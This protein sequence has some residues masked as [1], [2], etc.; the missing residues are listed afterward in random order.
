MKNDTF[1]TNLVANMVARA[2]KHPSATC[3]EPVKH[4][5]T[6]QSNRGAMSG[7]NSSSSTIVSCASEYT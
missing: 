7:L 2:K 1:V 5:S 4:L 3:E 6:T